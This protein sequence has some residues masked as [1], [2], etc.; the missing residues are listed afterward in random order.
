MS[1]NRFRVLMIIAYLTGLVTAIQAQEVANRR[2][3]IWKDGREYTVMHANG[4]YL[5]N[6][7]QGYEGDESRGVIL[8]LADGST[9]GFAMSEQPCITLTVEELEMTTR[10]GEGIAYDAQLVRRIFFGDV[11][12]TSVG[13]QLAKPDSNVTF[14]LNDGYLTA[15]GLKA[16]ER[17]MLYSMDGKML[18]LATATNGTTRLVLPEGMR[19]MIVKTE[20]GKAFK[21]MFG[22]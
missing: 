4:I 7:D 5:A 2:I 18:Q 8:L 20:S 21:W 19:A 16:G 11:T 1:K 13:E 6:S 12:S 22:R 3:S 14:T 10:N 15:N 9:V 17:V